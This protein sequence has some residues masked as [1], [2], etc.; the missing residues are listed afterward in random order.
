MH[1]LASALRA[2]MISPSLAADTLDSLASEV[3]A[4]SRTEALGIETKDELRDKCDQT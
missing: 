1:N 2:G 3:E 4:Y